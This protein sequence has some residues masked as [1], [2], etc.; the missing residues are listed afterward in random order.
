MNT[1]IFYKIKVPML[2]AV[3]LLF[4]CHSAKADFFFGEPVNLGPVIN[5]ASVDAT[6]CISSDNLELYFGSNRP[7]GLGDLDIWVSTRQNV[8]EAWGPAYN[9]GAPVNSP[10]VEAYPSI[11]SDGLTLYFS[12]LYSGTPR[13]G[14]LGGADIWM[15]T[16]S[17]RNDPWATPV[18]LGAPIN[19][20]AMDISPTISGDGLILVFA[21]SRVGTSGPY[22]LWM[23]TR[24]TVQD[25]WDTPV[26]L[27]AN[28]NS[29]DG[30]L[31]CSMS[32]DGLALFFPSG[33]A[34]GFSTYDL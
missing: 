10:Y 19:S 23:S 13:P 24:A 25:P 12:D 9:I 6:N 31:E 27:G 17:S 14:G 1:K 26:N 28:V 34:G 15:A 16:R 30:E 33:R 21:S 22:D 7:G 4:N 5:T 20:S 2:F 32:A 3:I 18:N 11:S 8:N 29:T